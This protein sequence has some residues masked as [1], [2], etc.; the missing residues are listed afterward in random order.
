MASRKEEQVMRHIAH[1]LDMPVD[2][3]CLESSFVNQGGQSLLAIKLATLCRSSGIEVSLG[4]ILL[5]K[6]LEEIVNLATTTT[7]D[8]IFDF[9]NIEPTTESYISTPYTTDTEDDT[10]LKDFDTRETSVDDSTSQ[11]FINDDVKDAALTEMQLSFVHSFMKKPGSNVISF[12][13]IYQTA[14]VPLVKAAWM[15]IIK[16]EPVFRLSFDSANTGR[17]FEQSEAT[18]TWR[19][20][21][22][23]TRDEYEKALA[24]DVFPNN[25]EVSFDFITLATENISAVV[26]RVH[27]AFIDGTSAQLVYNKMRRILGGETTIA[28]TPFQQ[29]VRKLHNY[30]RATE[31]SRKNFWAEEVAKH[32]QPAY[33]LGLGSAPTEGP[34]DMGSIT[35]TVPVETI[36]TKARKL[37]VSIPS[38]YQA[39]WALVLSLYTDSDTVSFGTVLSGRN[40]PISGV[41]DTVGPLINTLPFNVKLDQETTAAEYL[42]QILKHSVQ[43]SEFQ[44]S[45]PDDGFTR[46]FTTA[47]AMEF[48]MEPAKDET[49]Q[50]IGQSW[51]KT[52]PDMPMSV[53]MTYNGTIRLCFHQQKYLEAD[54]QILADYFRNAIMALDSFTDT[55]GSI[56]ASITDSGCGET[57]MR[58]GNCFSEK[59]SPA[60][61]TED[62]VTLFERSARENPSAIAV[63]KSDKSLTYAEFDKLTSLLGDQFRRKCGVAP[64]DVIC[65][66][67]DRSINWIIAIFAILKA[68]AVYSAQD[69]ALPA[70][71]RNTNFQT[72]GAKLFMTTATSQKHIKPE[73][74]D[75]CFSV[76]ELLSSGI[77]E[78]GLPH[79]AAARP[80]DNAYLCFTSGSTGKPKGVMC[81]HAGLVAFQITP[82]VRFFARPGQRISQLMSPAFDGSI[83]EIFSALC[84]GSTLV[85]SGDDGDPFAHLKK[86]HAAIMTPSIAKILDPAAY[87]NLATVYLV[88]EPVPQY[89]SDT[90]SRDPNRR[91]YN[92]YGPTEATCGATIQKLR[93][94]RKVTIGAPNAT[95]RV[96]VLDRHQRLLPHGVVGEIYL[97]GVQV[98]RGYIQRPELTAERFL[99]DSVCPDKGER[100]YRTGDR[101][102]FNAEGEV[103][104][105]G[106]NDRQIKLRGFRLDLNDLEIRVA[107]AVEGV[108]AVAICPRDDYLVCMLQPATLDAAAAK[109][110]ASEVLPVNAVPRYILPVDKF[111]MTPAGKVDYKEIAEKCGNIRFVQSSAT[112]KRKR[113][114]SL[115]VSLAQVWREV[116]GLQECVDIHASSNFI[117]LGGHSVMQ[118]KLSSTLTKLHGIRN[119]L[120]LIIQQPILS[121]MAAQ[122]EKLKP[123]PGTAE[124]VERLV[125]LGSSEPS[126]IEHDWWLKYRLNVKGTSSF[127]VT[128]ACAID[129]EQVNTERLVEAWNFVLA[130]HSIFRSRF[131]PSSET[132]FGIRRVL[133][134]SV[135]QVVRVAAGQKLG[136]WLEANRPFR[137]DQDEDL[138]RVVVSRNRMMLVVSHILADLTTLETILRELALTYHG[139]D[140]APIKK[141]YEHTVQWSHAATTAQMEWWKTNLHNFKADYG[142]V[143]SLRT[144]RISYG[145]RSRFARLGSGLARR[146]VQYT[147]KNQATLHQLG[148]ASVAMAMQLH[149][150]DT[151]IVLGAPYLNREAADMETVGLFLEPLPIRIKYTAKD[152]GRAFMTAVQQASQ[153]AVSNAIPWHQI[154]EATGATSETEKYPNHPLLDVMVTFHDHRKSE[155]KIGKLIKGLEPLMTHTKGSKFLLLLEFCAVEDDVML[156]R[157]EYDTECIS[158]LQIMRVQQ[159]VIEALTMLVDGKS[160]SH[161]KKTLRRL[162]LPTESSDSGFQETNLFFGRRLDSLM[163]SNRC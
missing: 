104:C 86:V 142:I 70:H 24:E 56:M 143:E 100:M 50:P 6:S 137:L 53:Y 1:V 155:Q 33:S 60:F 158:K 44:C 107:Q 74:C 68:G 160:Y 88:G 61:I 111:P 2:D 132:K 77:H 23:N 123:K 25:M 34:D 146:L 3:L 14:K 157:M 87:T 129:A 145:G 47:L 156:L 124:S 154:L 78:S 55:I 151:D 133:S 69:A 117:S 15:A 71:I 112:K 116:L 97:A 65:V 81:H 79:R 49:V 16:T 11:I 113:L 73:S 13:E 42:E 127:N 48:E 144:Q 22:V 57:V 92:M 67:A 162:P 62:L 147:G 41:E 84:Y 91:L 106:R 66:H 110:R 90:W 125:P 32:P 27:H 35:I 96:Y 75:Q 39:A 148:L 5:A 40:L 141:A 80:G 4:T 89:V 114:S 159:L 20:T 63:E 128:Y 101:G 59:T 136:L 130:R 126:P 46:Q 103:E 54:I 51:F 99:A 138:I 134:S 72:A 12:Y 28:G 153:N 152:E 38:W 150:D 18:F 52:L 43:L 118:L 95:T 93:P 131:I 36:I 149:R 19:E 8:T 30:Q 120:P 29:V 45:I 7:S 82:E 105:L 109:A 102:F 76:E 94:G 140:L 64:G 58:L 9:E 37:G 85:L 161:V 135:P 139:K 115:E 31:T 26:W 98:A 121:D 83:H 108:T 122:I 21:V 17:F 119:L 163:N 10:V